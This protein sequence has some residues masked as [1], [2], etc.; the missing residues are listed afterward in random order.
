MEDEEKSG[1]QI[2]SSDCIFLFPLD[3]AFGVP[4]LFIFA[5]RRITGPQ[6]PYRQVSVHP[7]HALHPI[8]IH[9]RTHTLP[10]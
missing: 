9:N 7:I 5:V 4:E 1:P 8:H 10:L 2:S 3:C 6:L